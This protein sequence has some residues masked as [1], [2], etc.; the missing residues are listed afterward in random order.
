MIG[1]EGCESAQKDLLGQVG[2][3]LGGGGT[4]AGI[5]QHPLV[6]LAV[7]Q[8]KGSRISPDRRD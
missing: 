2:S 6:V 4:G 3:D 5:R 7:Q 1:R 8:I